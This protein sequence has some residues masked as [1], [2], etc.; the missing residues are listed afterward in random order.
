M[1]RRRS[2]RKD[3]QDGDGDAGPGR[4]AGRSQVDDS[5]SAAGNTADAQKEIE[6][7]DTDAPRNGS[8]A[9]GGNDCAWR[10]PLLNNANQPATVFRKTL[11]TSD[12]SCNK[13]VNVFGVR[14]KSAESHTSS[15]IITGSR[16]SSSARSSCSSLCS[17]HRLRPLKRAGPWSQRNSS[18]T[19]SDTGLVLRYQK[20]NVAVRC[21]CPSSSSAKISRS[22]SSSS[23]SSLPPAGSSLRVSNSL[24]CVGVRTCP[25]DPGADSDSGLQG[26]RRHRSCSLP[27]RHKRRKLACHKNAGEALGGDN[28]LPASLSES[29]EG[30]GA[31]ARENTGVKRSNLSLASST[32]S[33][34][35]FVVD[36]VNELP[37]SPCLTPLPES[38]GKEGSVDER[39]S[40]RRESRT[41]TLSFGKGQVPLNNT[42]GGLFS[43][44]DADVKD[45]KLPRSVITKLNSWKA[46]RRRSGSNRGSVNDFSYQTKSEKRIVQK[47]KARDCCA[48]M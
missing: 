5:L 32:C 24:S 29:I 15:S 10:A 23:F 48:I 7:E 26:S 21:A 12:G 39:F 36:P 30:L 28:P 34:S 8:D 47:V 40:F 6:D 22:S 20:N 17:S 41:K 33:G 1:F 35:K 45:M 31:V 18:S 13:I 4:L 25:V 38:Q 27:R 43:R 16:S 2:D 14:S 44:P 42:D 11:K 19:R 3:D 37:P 9:S 46:P